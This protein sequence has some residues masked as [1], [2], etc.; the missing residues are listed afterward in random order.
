MPLFVALT[1]VLTELITAAME[2]LKQV[3]ISLV[4]LFTSIAEI[5]IILIPLI[6]VLV[7]LIIVFLPL[8]ELLIPVIAML[9]PLIEL[10]IMPLTV[11]AEVTKYTLIPVVWILNGLL[12][13]LVIVMGF[14]VEKLVWLGNWVNENI[15][16]IWTEKLYWLVDALKDVG[17]WLE[18]LIG[19]I[20]DLNL[21]KVSEMLGLTGGS[22]GGL[23]G[24]AEKLLGF[25][26]GGVVPGNIGEPMM[27]LAHG[28]EEVIPVGKGG[29]RGVSYTSHD[30]INISLHVDK[31]VSDEDID[32]IDRLL[33]ERFINYKRQGM[34]QL[35][36]EVD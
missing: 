8:L 18:R 17:G 3:I 2:P 25:D 35:L 23:Q 19:Y 26:E 9:V 1:P 33:A 7:E 22:G 30:T 32:R 14:I 5:I 29:S 20:G 11:W 31:A 10:L 27:I 13:A 36:T 4:P 21:D 16:D 28:G 34:H 24:R 12:G 15:I 6:E